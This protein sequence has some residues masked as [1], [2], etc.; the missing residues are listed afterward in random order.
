MITRLISKASKYFVSADFE[1]DSSVYQSLN[2]FAKT[3]KNNKD[4]DHIDNETMMDLFYKTLH[5]TRAKKQIKYLDFL[6]NPILKKKWVGSRPNKRL[7][8]IVDEECIV[9]QNAAWNYDH[10]PSTSK[11]VRFDQQQQQQC[12]SELDERLEDIINEEQCAKNISRQKQLDKQREEEHRAEETKRISNT[13]LMEM[14]EYSSRNAN[15]R[16]FM[17]I[18]QSYDPVCLSDEACDQEDQI[19]NS[20]AFNTLI[21][22][23]LNPSGGLD[24]YFTYFYYLLTPNSFMVKLTC[25]LTC[26]I[27]F[28]Y[29]VLNFIRYHLGAYN[30]DCFVK[31]KSHET[32]TTTTTTTDDKSMEIDEENITLKSLILLCQNGGIFKDC[33]LI[34]DVN[35]N[36]LLDTYS[37]TGIDDSRTVYN[38][39]EFIRRMIKS[40]YYALLLSRVNEFRKTVVNVPD[41]TGELPIQ[42]T[43]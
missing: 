43:L 38:L 2:D 1:S 15:R 34:K 39:T 18:L 33:E 31:V 27:P 19:N 12:E 32:N 8:G 30:A 17:N 36:K 4:N 21:N 40:A 23:L 24:A 16:L 6:S 42:E 13:C 9:K 29:F 14:Y 26:K 25:K 3:D 5:N 28:A 20:N 22:D 35:L 37:I 41:V 7:S 11:K 10:G